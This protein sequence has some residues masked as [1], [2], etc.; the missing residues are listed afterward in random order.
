MKRSDVK[1]GRLICQRSKTARKNAPI[2]IPIALRLDAIGLSLDDLLRE[3]SNVL[4]PYLVHHVVNYPGTPAGS[5]V[6]LERVSAAFLEARKAAGIPDIDAE[7]KGAPTFHEIRSLAKRLYEKQGGVDTKTLLG[8]ATDA[9][10]ELYKDAR[11]M[12]PVEVNVNTK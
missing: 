10:S 2:A 9:M 11:D 7:G 1:D 6:G 3:R 8:H 5:P 12:V 4:S